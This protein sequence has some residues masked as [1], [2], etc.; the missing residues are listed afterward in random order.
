VPL[1]G[2][3]VAERS[4]VCAFAPAIARGICA[5]A[6]DERVRGKKQL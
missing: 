6:L 4:C 2:G 5:W 3:I 1:A